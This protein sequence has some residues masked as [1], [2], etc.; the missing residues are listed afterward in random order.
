MIIRHNLFGRAIT[1]VACVG[2]FVMASGRARSEA[3]SKPEAKP[4]IQFLSE[5][6]KR[7]RSIIIGAHKP[8]GLR[9]LRKARRGFTIAD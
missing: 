7:H 2:L 3:S 9:A 5:K 6:C 4:S 8:L 1:T